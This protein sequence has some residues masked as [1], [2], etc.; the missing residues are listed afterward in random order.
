[1]LLVA[2]NFAALKHSLQRRKDV[3][4]TPYINHPI[5][6]AV[7]LQQVGGIKNEEVLIAALLHDTVEDTNTT[8]HE[9]EEAFGPVVSGIVAEVTDNKKL[10]KLERKQ[11][12]VENAP[13]KSHEAKLVKLADKLYNLRDLKHCPPLGWTMVETRG[14][15]AWAFEVVKGLRGT[16]APLEAALDEVF[17]GYT[18]IIGGEQYPVVSKDEGTHRECLSRYYEL[19]NTPAGRL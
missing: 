10:S 11:L 15:F 2:A 1:M 6:V 12:Q 16:N 9:I 18:T 5:G 14:Y 8:I 3:A 17:D 19:M 4:G 7:L 13:H